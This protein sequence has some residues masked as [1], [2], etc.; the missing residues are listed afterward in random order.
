MKIPFGT[1]YITECPENGRVP[2]EKCNKKCGV[3]FL[4]YTGWR[5]RLGSFLGISYLIWSQDGK[6]KD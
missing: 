5:V 6:K 2:H 3:C 1:K 4:W